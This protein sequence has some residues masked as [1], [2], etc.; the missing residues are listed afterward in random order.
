MARYVPVVLA[1]LLLAAW[2]NRGDTGAIADLPPP[3]PG[4]GFHLLIVEETE[5]RASLTPDQFRMIFGADT[6]KLIRDSGCQFRI[7]DQHVNAVGEPVQ[8]FRDA[9]TVPRE[10]IPWLIISNGKSGYSGPL[11]E[12]LEEFEAI[13]RRYAK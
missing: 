6:R 8:W 12:K 3:V 13:V 4:E 2:F 10:S 7:W 9:L 11:P 5:Q 1:A